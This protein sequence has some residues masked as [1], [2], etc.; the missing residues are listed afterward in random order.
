[1]NKARSRETSLIGAVVAVFGISLILVTGGCSF[2]ESAGQVKQAAQQA[3]E[4]AKELSQNEIAKRLTEDLQ[5]R[6]DRVKNEKSRLIT[7]DGKINWE[8][9]QNTELGEH[10]FVT[11]LDWEYKAVLKANGAVDVLRVDHRSGEKKVISTY[12]VRVNNGQVTLGN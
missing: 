4:Q 9:A 7:P 12:Q 3:T 6:V 8:E 1:M 2:T 5:R 10:S 11:V